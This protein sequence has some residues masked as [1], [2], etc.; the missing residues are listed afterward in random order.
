MKNTS[1]KSPGAASRFDL[2]EGGI[3]NKLLMISLPVIGIQII[4]MTYNL[5]DMFW[6]GRL[7]S[8]AV[9]ACGVV[10]M[11]LWMSMAF[12][13]TGSR[14]AEIGVSQ[15]IGGGDR[16][17]ARELG[18]TALSLAAINGLAV[19]ALLIILRRQL[20]GFFNLEQN[21]AELAEEYMTIVGLGLPFS[22]ISAT[23]GS[24]FNGSGNSRV[25]FAVSC[26]SLGTNIVLDPV[27]IFTAGMGVAGA[28]VATVAAQIIACVL[29]VAMLLKSRNRPFERFRLFAR[30]VAAHVRQIYRWTLPMSLESFFFT[31]LTMANVRMIAAWGTDAVAAQRVGSQVESLTWLIGGGYSVAL[32]SYVGQNFGAGKWDRIRAGYRISL[33]L[34]AVWGVVVTCVLFFGGEA[35]M[36][37]FLPDEAQ[38]VAIGA[39]Y[40]RIIAACQIAQ[41]LEGIAAGAFRGMG[42]TA[43]PSLVSI[44]SNAGRVV[45]AFILSR[46]ALG[47]YG[48]FWAVSIGAAVRGIWLFVWYRAAARRLTPVS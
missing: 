40:V 6:L 16:A 20:I 48:I 32:T 23:V 47:L 2:T 28:A 3:L 27:L 42:R 35:L 38:A 15:S 24:I 9:A 17:Q 37:V 8:G 14:G 36:R 46:T 4:Q 18:E 13:L 7:S 5:T 43:E 44:I 30:P 10:G 12:M 39:A 41:C 25:P 21:V 29:M 1:A 22:F 26:V 34:M 11:Y 33:G 31:F 19:A 45:L